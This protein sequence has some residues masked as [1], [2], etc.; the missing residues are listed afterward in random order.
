M[1]GKAIVFGTIPSYASG[2]IRAIFQPQGGGEPD[3]PSTSTTIAADG[4]FSMQAWLNTHDVH[5]P[6][7]TNFLI[8]HGQ[9]SYSTVV[10]ITS[11]PHDISSAFASAPI[12]PLMGE[13]GI[14]PEEADARYLKL[15]GSNSM[16]GGISWG[17]TAHE[18]NPDDLTQLWRWYDGAEDFGMSVTTGRLNYVTTHPDNW[19]YFRVNETD[20]LRVSKL[21][22]EVLDALAVITPKLTIAGQDSDERYLLRSEQSAPA[23]S[24]ATIGDVK[25]GFQIADHNGWLIL[26]GRGIETLT[27]NQQI[28]AQ[29]LGFANNIPDALNSIPL[30]NM[31][32]SM[33]TLTGSMSR[34]L[35]QENLPNVTLTSGPA[36]EHNHTFQSNINDQGVQNFNEILAGFGGTDPGS[37]YPAIKWRGSATIA[38]TANN[39]TVINGYACDGA[40]DHSHTVSLGGSSTPVDITPKAM[41]VNMFVYLG[42]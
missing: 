15:D 27:P 7:V 16:S 25:S 32:G 10:H 24:S 20:I 8:Q 33:G 39:G 4:T 41:T 13:P 34:T 42:A 23:V 26:N 2:S 9:T 17:K 14:S 31:A 35:T 18:S 21:G 3:V 22:L 29:G 28:A 11:D 30:Q 12:P 19:H 37:V 36:G 38:N 1:T 40:I 5:L 6:S